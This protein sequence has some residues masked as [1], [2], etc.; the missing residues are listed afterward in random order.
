MAFNPL[1]IC[2][3]AGPEYGT[4]EAAWKS[5][6]SEADRIADIHLSVKDRL[7]NE[8]QAE[9][10]QWKSDNYHKP[11]VGPYKETK[12]LEDEFRKA[13]KPWAKRLAKVMDAK[14]K[15]HVACKME[16][17]ATNQENNARGDSSVSGEQVA[18]LREWFLA[19]Y[20][21]WLLNTMP[22]KIGSGGYAF[23]LPLPFTVN[24]GL[25]TEESILRSKV[26][27]WEE[28][29]IDVLQTN[30]ISDFGFLN[31]SYCFSLLSYSSIIQASKASAM[32]ALVI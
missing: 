13:Q 29:E 7:V 8:V 12:A 4:T 31:L 22:P 5:T 18:R 27:S 10:K 16:K 15:Y 17:S 3:L 21:S 28:I 20:S 25:Q 24:S 11:M 19:V 26:Q 30:S 1:S 32:F 6:L 23:M 14:K 9:I 2:L